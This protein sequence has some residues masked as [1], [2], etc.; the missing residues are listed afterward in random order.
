[1]AFPKFS[2]S[3]FGGLSNDT[4]LRVKMT[5]LAVAVLGGYVMSLLLG[6][7]LNQ[8]VRVGGSVYEEIKEDRI[9]MELVALQ[10]ADLNQVIA[11]LGSMADEGQNL[12]AIK[13]TRESIEALRGEVE[14][15]FGALVALR[16]TD[17]NAITPAP[18]AIT[19]EPPM[20]CAIGAPAPRS[21]PKTSTAQSKP[22]N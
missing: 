5:L 14:R 9:F 8:R 6:T 20:T 13:A 16:L 4:S 2:S 11:E 7:Y 17:E 10:K 15:R 21:S 3:R 19:S 1:M 12:D 18:S 22:H